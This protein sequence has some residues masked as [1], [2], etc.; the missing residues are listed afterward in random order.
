VET[1][2]TQ[3]TPKIIPDSS[4]LKPPCGDATCIF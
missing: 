4:L 2:L 3:I 1:D